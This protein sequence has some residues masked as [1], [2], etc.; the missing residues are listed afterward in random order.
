MEGTSRRHI[1]GELDG[2]RV[3][4][5]D[6]FDPVLCC[7]WLNVRSVIE[8]VEVDKRGWWES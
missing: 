4:G 6:E 8:D 1:T 5:F 3:R 2:L 7:G